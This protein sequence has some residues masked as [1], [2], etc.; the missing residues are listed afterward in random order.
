AYHSL[1]FDPA[2][3]MALLFGGQ[4]CRG[5][6]YEFYSS[7]FVARIAPPWAKSRAERW[8]ELSTSGPRPPARAQHAAALASAGVMV[9]HGGANAE[10]GFNDIWLLS[11]NEGQPTWA[12]VPGVGG[13]SGPAPYAEPCLGARDFD[14][15]SC[16]PFLAAREGRLLVLGRSEGEVGRRSSPPRPTTTSTLG[17][18]VFDL[19]L[20]CWLAAPKQHRRQPQQQQPHQQHQQQ[21][22]QHQQ[23]QQQQHQQQQEQEQQE[24]QQQPAWAGNFAAWEANCSRR[25]LVFGGEGTSPGIVWSLDLWGGPSEFVLRA[26]RSLLRSEECTRVVVSFLTGHLLDLLEPEPPKK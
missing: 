1:V 26:L 23:Q 8:L 6:P 11:L 16:R 7:T 14:V 24:Q 13:G 9:V 18:F 10:H 19:K 20:G 3:D 2:R 4:V 22:Q 15:D 25:V 5:G 17:L 12:E 21:Q